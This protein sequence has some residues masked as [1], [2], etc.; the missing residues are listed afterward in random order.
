MTHRQSLV[1]LCP[2]PHLPA[3][4]ALAAQLGWADNELSVPLSPTGAEPATHLG[5]HAWSRDSTVAL[6]QGQYVPEDVDPQELATVLAGLTV[7]A[8]TDIVAGEH[9]E[10]VL[11]DAGLMRGDVVIARQEKT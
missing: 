4:N 9:F 2:V 7:S 5:L 8:R 1:I 6:F 10:A 11:A 3:A